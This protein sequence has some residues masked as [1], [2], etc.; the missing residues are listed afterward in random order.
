[1]EKEKQHKSS[2][3]RW[4]LYIIAF[5][6]VLI[7]AARIA[8]KSNWLLDLARDLAVEQV[9]SQI[10]GTMSIDNV[11]GDLLNG[12]IVTG[13][14]LQDSENQDVLLADT[15]RVMYQIVSLLGSPHQVDELSVQG[16]DIF[17]V[18]NQD[19]T[20]NIQT[21]LPESED[22]TQEE[23]G[24]SW[25]A[26]QIT[27]SDVNMHVQSEIFL[28]DGAVNLEGLRA[29]LTAGSDH[30]G[31]YG[32]LR[33]L[34]FSVLENNLPEPVDIW[35]SGSGSENRVTLETLVVQT[36]RSWFEMAGEY[37]GD[38][39]IEGEAALSPLSWRDLAAYLEDLPLQQDVQVELGAS[40]TLSN[41]NLSLQASAE[42]MD[43]L[44]INA[45]I[46]I[47]NSP[48]LNRLD[49]S[50]NQINT[51][52]LT[53]QDDFPLIDSFSFSG[54]GVLNFEHPDQANWTGNVDVSGIRYQDYRIDVISSGYRWQEG[55][56]EIDGM[57]GLN[58][59]EIE[60]LAS[61]ENL[62]GGEP[63]WSAGFSSNEFNPAMW[64]NNPDLKGVINIRGNVNGK[65]F[66]P[67]DFLAS[68]EFTADGSRFGEQSF[69]EVNLSGNLNPSRLE[70]FM[71]ARLE[72]SELTLD[73]VSE[74]WQS[75]PDYSFETRLIE[76]NLEELAGIQGFPTYLNGTLR[77][78]GS[79]MTPQNLA[80]T[81]SV[82]F[83]SSH[84]NHEP[85][86]TLWADIN[87]QSEFLNI[88]N[89]Q[90]HSPVAD[91][92]FSLRQ[93]LQDMT[94]PGNRLD[95][96]ASSKD[97]TSLA[98][99]FGFERLEAPGRFTG[100]MARNNDGILQFN[101]NFEFED[102]FVDTIFNSSFITG[103][104]EAFILDEPEVELNVDF[105]DPAVNGLSVQDVQFYTQTT[106][107]ENE[108]RGNIGFSVSDEENSLF[109]RG[110]YSVDS[111]LVYLQT[112]GL[113]FTTSLR[114][115][116]LVEPFDA[117]YSDEILSIDTLSIQSPN[118]GAYLTLWAPHVD[119]LRQQ[120]GLNAQNLNLGALQQALIGEPLFEGLLSAS[121]L[122]LN[123]PDTLEIS[124][125]GKLNDIRYESGEMD[126]LRFTSDLSDEWLNMEL[127]GWHQS[128]RLLYGSARI[129]FLPGDPLAFDDRFFDRDVE[130][131]F[132]LSN[133]NLN[134]WLSFLPE[135]DIEETEGRISA[136]AVL[137]GVAGNPELNGNLTITN[138]R[139]SG[140]PVDSV[141]IDVFYLHDEEN[142]ELEGGITAQGRRILD[143]SAMLPFLVDLR[144]AEILLPADE[145]SVFA[146]VRTNDFDLA[147]F[148]DYVDRD[149]I[150]QPGGRLDGEVT[151]SGPLAALHSEGRMNLASGS[152]RVVPAGITINEIQSRINF[153]QDRIELAE[154]SMRSGPG[155]IRASGQIGLDNLDPGQ[156][157]LRVR[158]NQF[159][160]ANTQDYNAIIDVD[161]TLEGT[162]QN[163]DFRGSLTF[164]NGFFFLQNFGER[165]VE[166]VRLE[167]EEEMES[168]AFYDSL[169][170][171]MDVNFTRQFFIRNRQYLDMEI[172]LEGQLDL[173][174]ER[175]GELEIFGALEG[176]EGYA[177]PLGKNFQL[178]EAVVSFFGPVDEP[179]LNIRTLFEPPQRETEVRIYYIIE[180]TAQEPSFR[181][182][183]EPELELQDI[184]SYTIFGRPFYELES[185]EQTVAGNGAGGPSAADLAIDVLLDRVEMLAAQRFGIDVVQ[186]DNSGSGSNS[187]TS[188]KTGWYLNQ[189]T[190]FAILN[191]ISS[192]RPRTLFIL[193]YLLTENL[194][195]ILT[196]GD[197]T[198]E[199][200]DLRWHYDY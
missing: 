71:A 8:L 123:S 146:N 169:A 167:E 50:S 4:V 94:N 192:T 145:D 168:F 180:G 79:G 55:R 76:F 190:F 154:F 13:I 38:D 124:A 81:A 27:L 40:G 99:L 25:H 200:I 58:G 116:R 118:G 24:I 82:R 36:S 165:S 193:E 91:A 115:L 9:N 126:S 122:F 194:E 175:N 83:D 156:L 149:L 177:R 117:T 51:P 182:E 84:V 148:R 186:I 16:I 132:N 105:T 151:I 11:R 110:E 54:E 189:R 188:I 62:T 128:D 73:F 7:A 184:I 93:H 41:L 142:V 75:E 121:V 102:V 103:T 43:N 111:T 129:P 85:I 46:T 158:G 135:N 139:F 197:D 88:E 101:G 70:A 26:D 63:V 2:K 28:P 183:S 49:I 160:A 17:A 157:Q 6:L 30:Q 164:L 150:R 5:I 61:G 97:L 95:F 112:Y 176:V 15:I 65:G 108:T 47:E 187:T 147:L 19:S 44:R 171:E 89:A 80:M 179:E 172:E 10:N 137:G 178:E 18:Q 35:L 107:A 198:R 144:A 34:D 109:H 69:S 74:N 45:G 96:N 196:Q 60:L 106:F 92:D 22:T 32:N 174:K 78:S 39:G 1:M 57:L 131:Q 31:F 98:S 136:E 87:I 53:G 159:R 153:E 195:L 140:I 120:G 191:E 166:D 12:F 33:A 141:G 21:L 130:G 3:W 181:F 86:D 134:Y 152:M 113:E 125:S 127:A 42:G 29:D 68:F 72:Q 64:L 185:W 170:M 114:T 14:R 23:E 133:S 163:P 77:G 119:S 155:R 67:D 66:N 161:A 48:V 56:A 199:G 104:I 37:R 20:W 52:L 138:G 59:Q 173:L 100:N 162:M 90:L 143:F